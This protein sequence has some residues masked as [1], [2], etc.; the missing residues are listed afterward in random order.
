MFPKRKIRSKTPFE[1]ALRVLARRDFFESEMHAKI[2][3]HFGEEAADETIEKLKDY[4]YINDDSARKNL[5]ASR[6]RSGYGKYRIV[7]EL[8]EKGIDADLN[9]M[10]DIA[11]ERGIDTKTQLAEMVRRY[12]ETKKAK[13]PYELKQK[14]IAHF[15][16]KGYS[17]NEITE[18]LQM[19][20][21]Q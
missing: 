16:R 15:Y 17:F 3:E 20:T 8:R 1:Y 14:C 19:E 9:D 7:E 21:E 5:I 6:L 10:Q 2:T 12:M 4:G 13:T 18:I 11:E